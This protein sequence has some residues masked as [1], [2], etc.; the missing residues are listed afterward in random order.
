MSR[1]IT[2]F[3][4]ILFSCSPKVQPVDPKPAWLTGQLNE[5]RYYTGVGQSFKDG[6]N[7]YVQAA[8]KSALDDLVSQIKVTVSS[9]SILSTL[10]ENRKDF[11]ERYEQIIQT[12]AADEIEEFEQ[13]GA[14]EDERNYW[15]YLRLS[16]ERYRQIK[17]EQKRN[18]VTLATDFFTKARKAEQEGTRLQ[19]ISFYFQAFRSVEKYLGEPI[20]VKI[21]DREV[22]L[23]NELYASIKS[24]LS[25]V[26][27]Q[28]EPTE[29][30]INRR[31][32]VNGQSV[33]AQAFFTDTRLPAINF[34]LRAAFEK[35]QGDVFPDY[36]TDEQGRA[37]I[38]LNKITSRELEQTV[39][40]KLNIDALSGSSGSLV[41]NL[42]ASTLKAPGSQVILK[43]QR[44]VVYLEATEKSLGIGK[45]STQIANRLKNLL[46]NAGF[47]FTNNRQRAD[48]LMEVNADSEKGSVSGSIYITFLTGV[49]RVTEAREG[50]VIYATTLDR[51]KGYGLDY[52]RSSQ[53]AYNKAIETLEKE[54]MAELLNNVLQ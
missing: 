14:Y 8:K 5:P 23:T 46:T 15:V 3:F 45:N 11:Q 2:L 17:E 42:I 53:D 33:T 41:Y 39:G 40:V 12:S 48:L 54:H 4:L 21:D 47:E 20:P 44:P 25:K 18:A 7:N 34:P 6:T 49:I 32:N 24:M 29:M 38:L 22:L 35:G 13:V 52:D 19:A 26:Q 1:I 9:T 37:K 36:I 28:V 31:M 51:I 27:V 16:K 43:V 30:S 50:R 10:E